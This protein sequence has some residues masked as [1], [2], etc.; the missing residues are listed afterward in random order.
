MAWIDYNKAIESVPHR[1]IAEFLEL[2]GINNKTRAF[3]NKAMIYWKTSLRL[4]TEGKI[5]E[6]EYTEIQR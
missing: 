4:H 2:I 3:T 6:R 5:T 1:C